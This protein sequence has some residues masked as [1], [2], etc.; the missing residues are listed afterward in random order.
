M[1]TI[2]I[3][4]E[5]LCS[6]FLMQRQLHKFFQIL[7]IGCFLQSPLFTN[8]FNNFYQN[9]AIDIS[10][11]C[12]S[13]FIHYVAQ[14]LPALSLGRFLNWILC[15]CE[16]SPPWCFLSTSLPS[17]TQTTPGSPYIFPS[18][19]MGLLFV[20]DTCVFELGDSFLKTRSAYC[21]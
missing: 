4:N 3:R 10:F 6:T 13:I 2:H 16:V 17:G 5:E 14:I 18:Q 9:G 1:C 15:P 11:I 19:F 20:K 7:L 12:N 21:Y 8:L